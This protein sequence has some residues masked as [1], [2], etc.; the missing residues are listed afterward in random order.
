LLKRLKAKL[1]KNMTFSPAFHYH[2][3]APFFKLRTGSHSLTGVAG[4]PPPPPSALLAICALLYNVSR[5]IYIKDPADTRT[6]NIP[7]SDLNFLN[8]E[9]TFRI[10]QASLSLLDLGFKSIPCTCNPVIC[11]LELC[12]LTRIQRFSMYARMHVSWGRNTV[13]FK[14]MVCVCVCACV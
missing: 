13:G 11:N 8:F 3:F 10:L 4:W 6:T 5:E 14:V 1:L 2:N 9:K 7:P 12:H